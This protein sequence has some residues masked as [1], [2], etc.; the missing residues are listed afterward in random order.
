MISSVFCEDGVTGD[1][2]SGF[3]RIVISMLMAYA[4]IIEA[5]ITT[6]S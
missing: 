5:G 6:G 1:V 4:M 2:E 3:W